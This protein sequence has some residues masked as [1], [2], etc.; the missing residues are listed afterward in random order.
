MTGDERD[1]TDAAGSEPPAPRRRGVL[2]RAIASMSGTRAARGTGGRDRAPRQRRAGRDPMLVGEALEEVIG[3]RGWGQV[4]ALAT[5][6]AGWPSIVG[7]ELADHLAIESLDGGT[8]TLRADSTAWATN[9]SLMLADLRR[10]IASALV[11]AL[12]PAAG[13]AAVTKV[14]VLGP[15]GPTWAAGPRRVK[16]RGPRDTYG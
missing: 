15:Q 13:E 9:V 4:S 1:D 3:E 11:D 8:L 5:L 6:Q 14:V 12:G 16:G 2:G 7:A 10:A